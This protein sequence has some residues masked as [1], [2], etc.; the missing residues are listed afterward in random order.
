M[1]ESEEEKRVG[2]D[3]R[4][5]R[6]TKG[7]QVRD[8]RGEERGKTKGKKSRIV[9][10]IKKNSILEKP[11]QKK[12]RAKTAYLESLSNNMATNP[13][14]NFPKLFLEARVRVMV[15]LGSQTPPGR[16]CESL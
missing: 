11:Q 1:E 14:E 3:R 12:E 16:E 2:R 9:F 10:R 8:G 4:D 7:K 6:K 5:G 15:T 13:Q